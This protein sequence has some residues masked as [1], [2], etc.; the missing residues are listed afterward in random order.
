MENDSGIWIKRHSTLALQEPVAIAGSPGL[1]SVGK[2]VVD[3]LIAQTGAKL[4]AELYST[5]LPSVYQ[6]KPSYAAHPSMPGMGGAVVE[7]GNLDF[8]KVQ[9]YACSSPPLILVRGY[10]PNFEGQYTVAENVLDL[11]RE[12]QVKRMIVA[13]GYGSKETK[14]C[15]AA[16]S[17]NGIEEMKKYE[18][19]VGYKGPFM[20]FSGL[21]FGLAKQKGIEAV[22][23]F[24][25]T[26]PKEDDLEFPD[27]EA[28]GRIVEL[29][30]R[31]L[32]LQAP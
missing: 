8:P 28:S 13:A 10:H 22:C 6:T 23:L 30:N 20:G 9:F 17:Q 1:R 5:H 29:L 19:G 2:L 11:L 31:I 3:S 24:A 12:A 15:C 25:G 16:S 14:I 26:A 27:K 18:V 21:V 7:S 32:G 4:F